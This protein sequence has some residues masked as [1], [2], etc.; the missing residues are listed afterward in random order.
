M[1]QLPQH[2]L[3]TSGKRA[4]VF[5]A[6]KLITR[7][8]TCATK[9]TAKRRRAGGASV[10]MRETARSEVTVRDFQFAIL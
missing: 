8:R 10:S 4:A 6:G 2:L 7:D 3:D 9:K 5:V 1:N